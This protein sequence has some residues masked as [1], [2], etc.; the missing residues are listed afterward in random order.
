MEGS[1]LFSFR[2]IYSSISDRYYR[3]ILLFFSIYTAILVIVPLVRLVPRV[4]VPIFSFVL[5]LFLYK[6]KKVP[7]VLRP[8]LFYALLVTSY[9]QLQFVV[10]SH[11]QEYHGAGIIAL[12]RGLFGGKLPVVWLQENLFNGGISWYDYI[13]AIFH[14]SLFFIPIVFP[15]MLCAVRYFKAYSQNNDYE[16]PCF[17]FELPESNH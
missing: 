2:T 17:P 3:F 5:F 1:K 16:P 6:W 10:S 15:L 13:F 8:W 12:E 7:E 4:P 9:W 11:F 14:S